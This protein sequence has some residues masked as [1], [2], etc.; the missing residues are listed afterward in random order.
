MRIAKGNIELSD[1]AKQHGLTQQQLLDKMCE[2]KLIKPDPIFS[3]LKYGFL[4]KYYK[5]AYPSIVVCSDFTKEPVEYWWE[6]TPLGQKYLKELLN[7][8]KTSNSYNSE[9]ISGTTY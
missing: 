4:D 5:E 9:P 7:L 6:I 3:G 1:F 2:A 8:K